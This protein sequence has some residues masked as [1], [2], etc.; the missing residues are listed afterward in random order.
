MYVEAELETHSSTDHTA[1]ML[2]STSRANCS[3]GITKFTWQFDTNYTTTKRTW[4]L[5]FMSSPESI[6]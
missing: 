5:R 4:V 1:M 6:F 2:P 3:A